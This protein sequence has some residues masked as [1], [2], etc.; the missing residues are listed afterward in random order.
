MTI[1]LYGNPYS[2]CTLRVRSVLHELGIPFEEQTIPWPEV[3]SDEFKATRHP[4]A[5]VP[6]FEDGN[7]K[8]YESRA[9]SRYLANKYQKPENALL[10]KDLA[11][12]AVVDQFLSVETSYFDPH[13]SSLAYEVSF[14][15][16]KGHGDTDPVLVEKHKTALSNTLDIYE[17]LLEGKEY[18]AGEFSLADLVHIPYCYYVSSLGFGDLFTTSKRPNVARWYKALIARPSWTKSVSTS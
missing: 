7:L 5:K 4:F 11:K 12:L 9:I 14:K 15:K 10:P 17:K 6:A 16:M 2:T 1:K 18:L 13:I 3:G 8:L